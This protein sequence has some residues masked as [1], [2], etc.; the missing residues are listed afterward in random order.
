MSKIADREEY[1]RAMLCEKDLHENPIKQLTAWWR[2]ALS[3]NIRAVDAVHLATVDNEG[4]ADGRIVL[5]KH[6]DEYGLVFF[7]NYESQ[8]ATQLMH[9][10]H[11]AL[12]M[13]WP[14]LERQVRVRGQVSK[15]SRCESEIYFKSRPRGA[16]LAAWASQQSQTIASRQLL[17]DAYARMEKRFFEQE[18]PC[19]E[20]WGGFR[21]FPNTFEF[22][23]GRNN[24]LHDRFRYRLEGERWL[25][26]R[27]SP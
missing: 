18:V 20:G 16:R 3:S 5:L 24:R 14:S 11:A 21:L 6:F 8:K 19:P 2:E 10:P 4:H 15:T 17:E 12:T 26:E 22:W 1:C 25:I 13:F 23:Q 9:N 7:T 27:L